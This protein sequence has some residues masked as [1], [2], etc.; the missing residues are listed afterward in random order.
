LKKI[1]NTKNP[2][3][4]WFSEDQTDDNIL[5]VQTVEK[6]WLS[7]YDKTSYV[8]VNEIVLVIKIL[9]IKNLFIFLFMIIRV[10]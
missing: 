6:N 7:N 3:E 8:D 9:L 2:K 4:K 10:F 1:K 5:N